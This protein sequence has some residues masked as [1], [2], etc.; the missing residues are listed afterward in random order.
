METFTASIVSLEGPNEVSAGE[1]FTVELTV[2]YEFA[3]P[4]EISPGVYDVETQ[5]F[6]AEE[7]ETLEG[8]GTK[9]YRFELTAPGEETTWALAAGVWYHSG[10]ELL[11][12]DVDWVE[13]FDIQ[14][15]KTNDN[16]G[17][18]GFPYEAIIFGLLI[19]FY[20]LSRRATLL[21]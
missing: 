12:D 2:T 15:M 17:I 9:T 20:L 21:S 7:Y 6:L 11:H 14:V 18:P 16:S 5:K 4:T 3:V 1:S 10:G 19:G 8:Q 13:S